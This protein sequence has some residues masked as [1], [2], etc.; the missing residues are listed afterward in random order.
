MTIDQLLRFAVDQGASDLHLQAGTAPMVRIVGQMRAIDV[1]ALTDPQVRQFIRA[2]APRSIIDDID[3]AMSRGADF[4]YGVAGLARFRCNLYSH[5]G[6]PG[7]VLRVVLPRIRSLEE[8]HLPPILREIALA[9]R[10]LILMSG[11][12]G[13]GKST[14][15]AA[16][17]D[18]LNE[19]Y[20]L[21]ILTIEDPV[22]YE[23]TSKR[24]LISHVEVG[25]DI[26]SFEHGLRQAMRQA[27]DVILVGELRDA[28][29]VRMV[30]RAADTG[31]Q[32]LA[33]IHS[34]SAAQTIERLLAMVPAAELAVA[35]Q[36]LAAA[37]VGII[38][39]RLTVSRSGERWPVVEVLRGDS[40][41]SKYILENRIK[42][43]ADYIATGHWG[44]QTFD[45]HLLK[46]HA[47]EV[48]SGT[49]ALS[50]ATNPEALAL[51][52]RAPGQLKPGRD[53]AN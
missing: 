51:E 49:Q 35:R 38:S 30:L 31:H 48:I 26:P 28:E 42:D 50:V 4:S 43:I 6:S 8:L 45:T 18:L 5:L 16:L 44:M 36:Q 47:Q 46:L 24:A 1:P 12:T 33:T 41:V 11:A 37:L 15:L 13:S 40:V 21:K 17:V 9:R 53:P 34:S 10:G 19:S 27:P 3:A 20:Y 14:T 52:M 25:R 22:E 23:H 29:S 2:L 39:Q 7:L 32:V